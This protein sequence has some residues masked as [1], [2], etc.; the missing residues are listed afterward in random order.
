MSESC[1]GLAPHTVA[2]EA[3]FQYALVKF[4]AIGP[5]LDGV[6]LLDHAVATDFAWGIAQTEVTAGDIA[7]AAA[8]GSSGVPVEVETR[9]GLRMRAVAGAAFAAGAPL[10]AGAGALAGKVVAATVPG[11]I[12]HALAL[13]ASTADGQIVMVISKFEVAKTT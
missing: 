13:E 10:T 7:D 1:W 12:V 3:L 8:A 6:E 5:D 11:D 2:A 4:V 9:P